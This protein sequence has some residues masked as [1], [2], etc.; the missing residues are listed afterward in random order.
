MKRILV[1]TLLAFS[2]AVLVRADVIEDAMK[3]YHKGDNAP[4]KKVAGGTASD[5]ELAEF[6]KVYKEICA[7]KP[8]KG[9]VAAWQ[10]KCKDLVAA[11]EL[12]QKKDPGGIAAY[13]KA[14]NC[15]ACHSEHKPAK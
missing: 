10:A 5:A 8:P 13:K 6:V 9:D 15:K 3:K 7:A 4:C 2:S 14:V 11:V 1:T 12:I